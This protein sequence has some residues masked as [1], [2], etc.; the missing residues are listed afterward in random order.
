[1]PKQRFRVSTL[2]LALLLSCG[3]RDRV[4]EERRLA[5]SSG[6]YAGGTAPDPVPS[7]MV[8]GGS[9]G[10][11]PQKPPITPSKGDSGGAPG[12]SPCKGDDPQYFAGGAFFESPFDDGGADFG[13]GGGAAGD[14]SSMA[15][16]S[17]SIGGDSGSDVRCDA[18]A[19]F[20]KPTA[21]AEL[22]MASVDD[23]QLRLTD[24]ERTA[25]FLSRRPHDMAIRLWT[26]SRRT[27][28]DH[29]SRPV[30]VAGVESIGAAAF[31][32]SADL[33]TIYM[34]SHNDLYTAKRATLAEGFGEAAVF[35]RPASFTVENVGW[36]FIG[37]TS[38]SLYV[39]AS[40]EGEGGIYQLEVPTGPQTHATLVL[41][42]GASPT[43]SHDELALYVSGARAANRQC[44]PP[45]DLD[46]QVATR[47]S[48]QAPFTDLRWVS[49]LSTTR[50]ESPN[51]LSPDGCR[52]YFT[53][54]TLA[55]DTDLYVAEKGPSS[56]GNQ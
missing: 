29:F 46:V 12:P 17:G 8:T 26:A 32:L 35:Q 33:L 40:R 38:G 42:S 11:L 16:D 39:D 20:S 22:N 6:S 31:A 25:Y 51:W 21:L 48:I 24:D 47:A 23:Y 18:Y 27:R 44:L 15:G 53:H 34:N 56:V 5:P 52:L 28:F 45:F 10:G 14:R 50:G 37:A 4:V 19:P 49:A 1:M 36:P 2:G 13:V 30:Y 7:G 55:G 3:L 41:G 9:G 54:T 43:L